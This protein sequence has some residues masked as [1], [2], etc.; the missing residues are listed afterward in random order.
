MTRWLTADH[1]FFHDN[2]RRYCNRPFTSVGTMNAELE[3]QWNECIKPGDEVWHLGDF[4]FAP[5]KDEPLLE[6]LFK[7]LHG[8]KRLIYGSHDNQ[9][10][11]LPWDIV[12]RGSYCLDGI[13][14]VHDGGAF[15]QAMEPDCDERL[16]FCGHVHEIWKVRENLLNVGVDVWHFYPV[17]WDRARQY[18]QER[19]DYWKKEEAKHERHRTRSQTGVHRRDQAT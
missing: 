11:H 9:S 4:G 3:G 5:K 18:L 2:I 16:I 1:H 17:E 7:R 13:M 12:I 14:L 8:T 19:F 6:A 10:K 15:R